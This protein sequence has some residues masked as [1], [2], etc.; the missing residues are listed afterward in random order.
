MNYLNPVKTYFGWNNSAYSN[1]LSILFFVLSFFIIT[2]PLHS[3]HADSTKVT[4]TDYEPLNRYLNND[5]TLNWQDKIT[6]KPGA[7]I[8]VRYDYNK[9]EDGN[10]DFFIRRLRIKG[11]GKAFDIAT[12]YFEVKIDNTGKFNRTPR[13]QVENAWLD[14]RIKKAFI[15]RTGLFDMV[16]S[17]NA[18]T[19]DSKLLLM[20][21]S[22]IKGALTVLGIADNTVG[23]LVHGR[24]MGGKLSY[25]VGIFDNLGFEILGQDTTILSR[26]SNGAM[27]TGR[28][29]YDF[30][31]TAS[32]GGYGDYRGS[33]IGQGKRLTISGNAAYLSQAQIG[34]QIFSLYAYGADLF[35]NTGGL[36]IEAEY[37]AYVED[38]SNNVGN[39]IIG[40][41]Y[42]IQGGYLVLPK[43]ELAVRY[44]Q[45][46]PDKNVSDN[47]L[48]W[49]SLGI[50]YYIRE[51]NLKIQ[52]E[53]IFK[54]E[55]GDQTNNN[56]LQVQL[57]FDF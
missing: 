43:L 14:F 13:A 27:A 6:F 2:T 41:G 42:Y 24:P 15:I 51:H 35:F 8:Q 12:Y 39:N 56:L 40:S 31:D 28:I 32:P 7:R 46:D 45:L 26:K 49:T 22:L 3:Q 57:Q 44:Q 53:Y 11:G 34:D 18:L 30:F 20:D 29:G 25:G 37:D 55:E 21:R 33:Y 1:S 10:N 54:N 19:S 48:M 50:N 5:M 16:F 36:V 38:V 4:T 9:D 17:R 52:G 23:I 47:K